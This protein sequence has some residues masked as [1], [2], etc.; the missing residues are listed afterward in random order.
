MGIGPSNQ[1][2][3][4]CPPMTIDGCQSKNDMEDKRAVRHLTSYTVTPDPMEQV[5]RHHHHRNEHEP[6]YKR[7]MMLFGMSTCI[8]YTGEVSPSPASF[9]NLHLC[10]MLTRALYNKYRYRYRYLTVDKIPIFSFYI[11]AA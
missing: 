7:L 2:E 5:I 6:P 10:D 11:T 4:V 3:E 8:Y 9:L 1:S